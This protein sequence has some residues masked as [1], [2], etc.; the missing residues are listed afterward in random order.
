MAAIFGHI[1]M[2]KAICR[3]K[4]EGLN[5]ERRKRKLQY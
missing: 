4:T 2:R 1:K 3:I 5:E